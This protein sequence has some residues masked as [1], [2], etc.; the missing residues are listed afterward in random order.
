MV[1]I[2][3]VIITLKNSD[4][5]DL[6]LESLQSRYLAGTSVHVE[7]YPRR[8]ML[9]VCGIPLH[10]NNVLFKEFLSKYGK[11]ETAFTSVTSQGIV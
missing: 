11:V 10:Y 1:F 6:A 4:E 7:L 8:M 2:I 9:Y 3:I 5:V